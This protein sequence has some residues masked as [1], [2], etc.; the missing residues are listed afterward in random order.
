MKA[1]RR[2][3]LFCWDLSCK[4]RESVSLIC[5]RLILLPLEIPHFPF[6]LLTQQPPPPP[7]LP[8][9]TCRLSRLQWFRQRRQLL[10]GRRTPR[11]WSPTQLFKPRRSP[12]P[13]GPR[14]RTTRPTRIKRSI[15]PR[16]L[17]HRFTRTLAERPP[18]HIMPLSLLASL[19][20]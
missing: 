15:P 4:T 2:K 9:D 18:R 6:R 20:P 19:H 3:L 8:P 12:P 16:F 10:T 1:T 5:A 14:H 7:L 11:G 17:P 13:T